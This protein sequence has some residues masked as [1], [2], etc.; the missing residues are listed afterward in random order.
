[1]HVEYA[2]SRRAPVRVQLIDLA[3]R[4]VA[5]LE[6]QTREPGIWQAGWNGLT[7][8]GRKA[9]PGLYLLRL[10]VEGRTIGQRKVTLLE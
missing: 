5:E 4:V 9:A 8:D 2:L 6:H 10:E 7:M 1:M 3:G